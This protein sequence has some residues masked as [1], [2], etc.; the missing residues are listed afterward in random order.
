[1]ERGGN[2]NK[3]LLSILHDLGQY[4]LIKKVFIPF[5][6]FVE[7][8]AFSLRV[9]ASR[10]TGEIGRRSP[11]GL[12]QAI[13]LKETFSRIACVGLILAFETTKP[14]RSRFQCS[15]FI[16]NIEFFAQLFDY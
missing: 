1:M 4:S 5:L 3:Y 12:L 11:T 14:L 2:E 13:R 8:E 16:K 9:S 6:A 15:Y 7:T 10:N